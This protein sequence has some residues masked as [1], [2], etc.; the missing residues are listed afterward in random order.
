MKFINSSKLPKYSYHA[1]KTLPPG[2][3]TADLPVFSMVIRDLLSKDMSLN[4]VLS[5][6]D[7]DL[8]QKLI[9]RHVAALHFDPK[10]IQDAIDDPDHSKSQ[11]LKEAAERAEKIKEYKA[12]VKENKEFEKMVKAETA[13]ER[14]EA[15]KNAGRFDIAAM[16]VTVGQKPKNLR[17]AMALNAKIDVLRKLKEKEESEKG[18]K[19]R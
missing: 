5:K 10:D 17:E 6:E 14:R 15:I 8:I 1:K 4:M 2:A 12:F 16:Q 9:E 11:A 7:L 13:T 3:S 18:D 19:G